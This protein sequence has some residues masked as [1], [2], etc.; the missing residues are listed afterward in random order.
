MRC[1]SAEHHISHCR[2]I[3]REG[4]ETQWPDRSTPKQTI[5]RGN[6]PRVPA[7]VYVL[8]QQQVPNSFEVVKD[9]IPIFNHLVKILIH[10]STIHSFVNLTFMCGI[11]V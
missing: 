7:R 1:G 8:D 3:L 5:V 6:R 9:M 10:S 4:S 11:D 2:H